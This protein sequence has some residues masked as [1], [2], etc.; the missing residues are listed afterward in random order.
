MTLENNRGGGEQQRIAR[1]ISVIC[2]VFQQFFRTPRAC[3]VGSGAAQV[4]AEKERDTAWSLL[5]SR[6]T[7]LLAMGRL[8]K[9]D[10]SCG[11]E[12]G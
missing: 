2:R 9:G 5:N 11:A 1:Q 6:D 7:R 4:A 8:R 10:Q 3:A 12:L